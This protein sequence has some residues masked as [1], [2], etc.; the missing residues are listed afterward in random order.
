[1]IRVLK[2]LKLIVSSDLFLISLEKQSG[3]HF[4]T[5][6]MRFGREQPCL[7]TG[8]TKGGREGEGEAMGRLET[9]S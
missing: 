7:C 5:P 4:T 6:Q 1:M 8:D 3:D 9:M 2:S